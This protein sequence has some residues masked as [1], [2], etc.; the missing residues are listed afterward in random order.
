M[1]SDN[2]YRAA[3]VGALRRAALNAFAY[4]DTMRRWRDAR[5]RN[6]PLAV[7]IDMIAEAARFKRARAEALRSAAYLR[8]MIKRRAPSRGSTP[9]PSE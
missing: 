4:R 8:P 6:A 9:T 1:S 2:A 3:M 5:A 7:L